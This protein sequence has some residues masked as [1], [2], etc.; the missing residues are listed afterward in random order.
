MG[1]IVGY[2]LLAFCA[3]F[4]LIWVLRPIARRWDHVDQPGGRKLHERSIPLC[5]GLAIVPV[6][7]VFGLL[8]SDYPKM[9]ELSGGLTALLMLGVID[10][11]AHVPAFIR[12]L[13]EVLAVLVFMCFL[14]DV[15]LYSLGALLGGEQPVMTG[16]WA[17]VLT[18]FAAVSLL[19]GVNMIDGVDG[20]AGGFAFLALGIFVVAAALAGSPA[21][22]ILAVTAAA[23][24]AFL[25]FNLRTPWRRKA[26]VFLGDAG[27]LALGFA[28]VWFAVDLSQGDAAVLRPITMVWIFGLPIADTIYLFLRRMLRG[29]SPFKADLF[30]F[31]HLLLSLG[32]TPG[33]VTALWLTAAAACAAIGIAGEVYRIAEITMFTGYGLGFLIYFVGSTVAW[34]LL[35]PDKTSPAQAAEN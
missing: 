11:R 28:L 18:V 12:L 2:S 25:T 30:H 19:N 14:S 34:R 23:V 33:R 3:V 10:D 17:V 35:E 24:A 21:L 20:L 13:V 29:E 22:G 7:I 9:W 32:L 4:T 6:V 5:G 16:D 31:H 26:S 27:S 8:F 1:S 15:I